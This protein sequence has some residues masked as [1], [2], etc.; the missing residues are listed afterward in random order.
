MSGATEVERLGASRWLVPGLF[1]MHAHGG[2]GGAAEDGADGLRRMLD[3]HEA[4]GTTRMIASLVAN[5]VDE[6]V[7]SLETI[8]AVAAEDARL[9]GAHLEGPFLAPEKRGAHDP[10][11]LIAPTPDVVAALIEAGRG[12]LRMITI[13]PELPGA[14]EAVAAFADAGVVPAVGH[15]VADA[16]TVAAAFDAGARVLTHAFNAMPPIAGR[17]PGPLGAALADER[18]AIEVI[19]DGMHV[20]AAN[21]AWL[22]RAAPGRVVAVTD[23]MAA[24]GEPDGRYRLG[25]LDVDVRGGRA[26]VAGGDQLAGSTL[27]LDRAI[28]VLAAAGVPLAEAVASASTRPAALFGLEPA[29]R[30]ELVVRPG[31]VSAPT[32]G[33]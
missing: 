5:P 15:T 10:A 22:M 24:T 26:T 11:H 20:D 9:V 27:T 17:A 19:A 4:H 28:R 31:D 8:A 18:V 1:D 7:A 33:A 12:T 16:A 2:G 32:P 13:A 14:I 6:L 25:G 21:L 29:G 3:A 23:A 30:V